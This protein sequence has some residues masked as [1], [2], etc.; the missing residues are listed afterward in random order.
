MKVELHFAF[1]I[2]GNSIENNNIFYDI[3]WNDNIRL[4]VVEDKTIWEKGNVKFSTATREKR[5]M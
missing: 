2:F 3:I 1:R 4:G 5:N